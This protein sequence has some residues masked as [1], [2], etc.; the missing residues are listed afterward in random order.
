[1]VTRPAVTEPTVMRDGVFPKLHKRHNDTV[2]VRKSNQMPTTSSRQM[3]SAITST[4]AA[5]YQF[6]S[7]RKPNDVNRYSL[8]CITSLCRSIFVSDE[9]GA[10]AR[11]DLASRAS[12][13]RPCMGISGTDPLSRVYPQFMISKRMPSSDK[14]K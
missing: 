1:M 14:I 4:R 2:N 5:V 11:V 10:F 6:S 12:H 7:F 9:V 3:H 13:S 8:S